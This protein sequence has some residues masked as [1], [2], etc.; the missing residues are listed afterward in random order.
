MLGVCEKGKF[1]EEHE[2]VTN[3]MNEQKITRGKMGKGGKGWDWKGGGK[4]PRIQ[5]ATSSG[6][7][8]SRPSAFQ[9]V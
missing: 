5:R 3:M 9:G 7:G 1:W 4:G 2:R 8:T 6:D